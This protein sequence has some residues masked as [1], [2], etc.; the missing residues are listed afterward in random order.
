MVN[1][2]LDEAIEL[3]DRAGTKLHNWWRT[4]E[5]ASRERLNELWN[6]VRFIEPLAD[7]CRE[8]RVKRE[9]E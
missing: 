6:H 2:E 9:P 3:L 8:A 4:K 1:D 5:K 7:H